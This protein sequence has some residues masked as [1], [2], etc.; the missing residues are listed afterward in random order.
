MLRVNTH[1]SSVLCKR[2]DLIFYIPL[3]AAHC[4]KCEK[5]TNKLGAKVLMRAALQMSGL[6]ASAYSQRHEGAEDVCEINTGECAHP[7]I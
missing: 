5:K 1:P 7:I 4:G 6:N 2:K 3:S